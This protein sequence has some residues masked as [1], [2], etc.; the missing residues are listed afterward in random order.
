MSVPYAPA[1][2]PVATA[3]TGLWALAAASIVFWGLR[4]AA[5]SE[6]I[7]PPPVAA[8]QAI[9]DPAA[10]AQLLGAVPSHATVAATPEAASR[11][12]LLGV[13]ADSDGRGAALLV[14]DGKPA[15]PFRVG[16]KVA[17][18]YV[19]QSVTTRAASFGA[20]ADSAPAFTLQLPTRPLAVMSPPP[21]STPL[22]V[23]APGAPR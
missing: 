6:A 9:A 12:S 1:R 7:A 5:P 10:V 23:V 4:L 18:G 21:L 16:A 3:T 14:V 2:W 8:S 22:P 13:V 20:R 15:K 11:F 17:D 19:L